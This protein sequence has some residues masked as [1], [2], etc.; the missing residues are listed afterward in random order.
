MVGLYS[1]EAFSVFFLLNQRTCTYSS[2]SC[3]YPN[4]LPNSSFASSVVNLA[5]NARPEPV[6]HTAPFPF[7]P[8]PFSS[9]F[10]RGWNGAMTRP[11]GVDGWRSRATSGDT[12]YGGDGE[13]GGGASGGRGPSVVTR[14]GE[15]ERGTKG[16]S[17][18][19]GG[20]GAGAGS[21]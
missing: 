3:K 4:T 14:S 1:K 11:S 12:R 6:S 17:G 5:G 8:A 21:D 13:G 19:G 15:S 10:G 16:G 20:A 9:R 7:I 2:K 18:I